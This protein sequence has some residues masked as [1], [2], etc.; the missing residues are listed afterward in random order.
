M[1]STVCLPAHDCCKSCPGL[2]VSR[3]VSTRSTGGAPHPA[4]YRNQVCPM[5]SEVSRCSPTMHVSG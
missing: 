5:M 4:C 1:M 2:V 3:V